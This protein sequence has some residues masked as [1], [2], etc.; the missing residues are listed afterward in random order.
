M[1]VANIAAAVRGIVNEVV[2]N[3]LSTMMNGSEIND[4]MAQLVSTRL[5]NKLLIAKGLMQ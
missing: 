3:E 5:Q 2:G 4:H 1:V